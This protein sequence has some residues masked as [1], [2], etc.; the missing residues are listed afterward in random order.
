MTDEA[1]RACETCQ[2]WRQQAVMDRGRRMPS[3][4]GLCMH[5]PPTATGKGGMGKWPLVSG[6]GW[7]GQ[8]TPKSE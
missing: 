3:T 8:W 2:W 6:K 4:H 7:C 5:S 1:E